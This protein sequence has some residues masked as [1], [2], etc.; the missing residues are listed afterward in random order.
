MFVNLCDRDSIPL[1]LISI[2]NKFS[3]K[4]FVILELQNPWV[5]V[6]MKRN[7]KYYNH[8]TVFWLLLCVK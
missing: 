4:F 5:K 1:L 8:S 3:T 2:E 6:N 7:N